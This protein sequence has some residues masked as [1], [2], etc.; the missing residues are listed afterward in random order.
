MQVI[1]SCT[2]I[3]DRQRQTARM[4]TSLLTQSR[5]PDK[6]HLYVS[7]KPYLLDKGIKP[8]CLDPLLYAV[9]E[10][11]KRIQVEWVENTGPYRKLLPTLQK[12]WQQDIIVITCDDDVEYNANFIERAVA[13]YEER[14]CS[15]GFQG[16]RMNNTLDY[17]TFEDAKGTQD[18]WNLAKGVGGIVYNPKW[19][20]NKAMLAVDP[21]WK[22]DDLWFVAWRIASGIDC[23]IAEQSSVRNSLATKANLWGAYNEQNNSVFLKE[24]FLMFSEQGWFS[25]SQRDFFSKE[26]V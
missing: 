14:Q 8:Y 22:N 23:Y 17:T 15:I 7:Q 10:K 21:R 16:T 6:I 20:S 9:T 19:F 1:V 11:D 24:I 26:T 2:T 12:Y 4:L 18:L 3:F 13:L 5:V 25:Q